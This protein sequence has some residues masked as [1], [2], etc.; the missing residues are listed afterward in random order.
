MSVA[1]SENALR[2]GG[3]CSENSN[4]KSAS[5]SESQGL[6]LTIFQRRLIELA[7]YTCKKTG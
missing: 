4:K 3:G 5:G 6:S 7:D 1:L 2:G